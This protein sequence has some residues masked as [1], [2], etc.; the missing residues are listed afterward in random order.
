MQICKNA[1][2]SINY[3][4][5][6]DGGNLI[7]SSVGAEPLLYLHG[8]GFLLQKLEDALEGKSVGDKITAVISPEDG[9]GVYDEKMVANIPRENFETT[10]QIVVGS[11]FQADTPDGPA[12][13]TVTKVSDDFITV[14]A[15]HELAGKTLHFDVEVLEVREASEDEIKSMTTGC[16]GCGGDCGGNCGCG[17]CE[18]CN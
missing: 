15:N 3:T 1:I 18:G 13:V 16:C 8:N 17:S 14:D 7:D 10:E 5:K 12:I 9:Y 11:K 4:V 6:D 2:V